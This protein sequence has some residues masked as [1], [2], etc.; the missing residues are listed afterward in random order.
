MVRPGMF[1]NAPAP[2][3]PVPDRLLFVPLLVNHQVNDAA[4]FIYDQVDP[5]A[6]L[7]FGAVVD[8]TMQQDVS[9]TLIATGIGGEG[10][11]GGSSSTARDAPTTVTRQQAPR[12]VEQEAA[13][14]P[15]G[16]DA[17]GNGAGRA[18]QPQVVVQRPTPATPKVRTDVPTGGVQ[19][20]DFLRR[21]GKK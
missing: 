12:Y 6:N 21:M 13:A 7:I 18:Q 16:M 2:V 17:G 14:P 1:A 19:I 4:D 10:A 9:I 8:P 11:Q 20:P 15:R 3:A 5:D